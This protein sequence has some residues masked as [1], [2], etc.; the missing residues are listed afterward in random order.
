MWFSAP[1]TPIVVWKIS[2]VGQLL[3]GAAAGWDI[4]GQQSAVIG[5][6]LSFPSGSSNLRQLCTYSV[7]DGDGG[8]MYIMNM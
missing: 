1:D 3:G 4:P 7:G 8:D 6:G 2:W 5:A